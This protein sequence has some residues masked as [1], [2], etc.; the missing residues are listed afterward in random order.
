MSEDRRVNVK[1]QS[2][3]LSGDEMSRELEKGLLDESQKACSRSLMEKMK[4]GRGGGG[5]GEFTGERQGSLDHGVIS[6][7]N[8]L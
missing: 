5:R 6:R 3:I 8:V 2:K 4:R 1:R 7:V